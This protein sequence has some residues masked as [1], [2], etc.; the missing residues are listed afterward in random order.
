MDKL[1]AMHVFV[2]IVDANSFSRAA[3]TLDLPRAALSATIKKLETYLGAQLL[4]RTTRTLSLT[5]EGERYYNE[6]A[7]ILEAVEAAEAPFLGQSAAQ[8]QGRLRV[9]LPGSLG[10]K[11]V[12][13]H[14][15]SFRE[16]YP[17]LDLIIS[18]TDR[19]VDLTQEGI[20]CTVRVGTLPDSSFIA[21]RLGT[22]RFLLAAA[23]GYVARRGMPAH[24][25]DLASHE[26]I[27]H[28]SGR[29]GR[30]FDWELETAEGVVKVAVGG[31]LAVNDADANL[32]CA[33]QGLGLAQ[34]ARYQA[35]PYLASGE[36]V[37]VL[38]GVTPTAMPVSLLYARG[39]MASPRLQA[40]AQWLGE[41]FSREPDVGPD[42]DGIEQRS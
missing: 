28:F 29:T 18:L 11:I 37:E 6:C 22:M 9:G 17:D 27:M 42:P 40:F 30:A 5:P 38:P 3:E 23:P 8:L 31:G 24:V 4:Q 41:V 26:G 16:R 12:L 13:P 21:R 35:R 19:L 7:T 39:R 10:R 15:H 2:R 14:I 34:L 1:R 33:L 25:G 36:L 32:G 20:D